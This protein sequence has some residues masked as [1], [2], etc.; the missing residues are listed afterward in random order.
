V[1]AV[2]IVED[3]AAIA[4]ALSGSVR[5]AGYEARLARTGREAVAAV[6]E[7]PPDVLVLDL[8]LPD[9]HGVEVCRRIRGWSR[10]PVIVVSAVDADADKVAALDAGADDYVTKPFRVG[11]LLAR[12]RAALRRSA[13]AADGDARGRVVFGSVEVDLPGRAVRRLGRRV[14]LTRQEF[15][16]LAVLAR[17]PGR[18]LTHNALV[19]RAW[20]DGE[21]S[22]GSLRFHVA[23]L[24]RKLEDDP[25]DPRHLI[26]EAGVGYRLA[27]EPW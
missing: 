27:L 12:I 16:V 13:P 2:L 19:G 23:S 3:D 9:L 5:A 1:T 11:E 7:T 8:L 24:R 6:A 15:E 22:V 10:V 25:S 21:G 20:D 17:E 14:P 18:V 26:T 4:R